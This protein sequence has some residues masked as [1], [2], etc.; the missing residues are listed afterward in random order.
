[1]LNVQAKL[2]I[3]HNRMAHLTPEQHQTAL[4]AMLVS[5][6]SSV[7]LARWNDGIEAGLREMRSQVR[8]DATREATKDQR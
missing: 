8:R 6:A 7:P 2:E 3:L 1:M 5:I 4:A